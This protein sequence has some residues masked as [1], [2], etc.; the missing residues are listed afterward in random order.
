MGP[1]TGSAKT[2]THEQLA[3]PFGA[4]ASSRGRNQG[5]INSLTALNSLRNH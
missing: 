4:P 5:L 3:G 1:G 2:V